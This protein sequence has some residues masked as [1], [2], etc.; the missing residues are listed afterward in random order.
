MK[1]VLTIALGII[2]IVPFIY[3]TSVS[4]EQVSS[5]STANK[6]YYWQGWAYNNYFK[7][8]LYITVYQY[9]LSI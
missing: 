6:P 8:G 5:N 3:E 9:N 4:A 2:M 1:K 7:S